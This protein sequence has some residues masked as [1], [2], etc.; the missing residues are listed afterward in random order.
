MVKF[1]GTC[2]ADPESQRRTAELCGTLRSQCENLVVVVSAMGRS[3][4][5]YST[6]TL[7]G[8][9][10][11]AA[12]PA[13]RDRL[14]AC[15]EI[16]SALV[17]AS[18]LRRN[19]IEAEALT[20][21]EAGIRTD[22][23]SGDALVLSVDTAGIQR[24]LA[25]GAVAVVAGFQG[26]SPEGCVTTLGRGGSDTTAVVLAAALRADEVVFYKTVESVFTAD[27]DKVPEA[28]KLDRICAEDL[29]QMA[30]QGAKIVNP[31]A[32]EASI[33]SGIPIRVRSFA[34]GE[35]VTSV[36]P[37]PLICENY[38][39]GVASGPP[40][41]RMTV[42]G[43]VEPYHAFHSRV[44]GL[45]AGAGVSM[46]MF[47]VFGDTAVFTV[48]LD[49]RDRVAGILEGEGLRCFSLAPCAKVS[50][51]GA[52]M[53][54]LRGVMARFS[55]ALSEAGVEMLQTVDSHATIS[56]LVAM[57]ERDT[58]LRALH[59]EFVEK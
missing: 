52:G 4:D 28:R 36:E 14:M 9:L 15:G 22:D 17:T 44:F 35:V 54:G 19:G 5:P 38:I 45:V 11:D 51:V 32:A 18:L 3:G 26:F 24:V 59:R 30:W 37:V 31:R 53:H 23:R 29:R 10:S 12:S 20:G 40:V 21:W 41:A 46:D 16:I 50:I 43:G 58:A 6:D 39:V 47:S 55:T 13:E 7:L 25:R 42:S 56:A 27:P 48:P 49:E 8:L 34:T 33:A 57:G 2:L 1:G